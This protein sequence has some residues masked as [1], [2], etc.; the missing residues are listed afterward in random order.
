MTTRI[1]ESSIRRTARRILERKGVNLDE[2]LLEQQ[3]EGAVPDTISKRLFA[4]TDED[5][6][7]YGSTV[8]AWIEK[9]NGSTSP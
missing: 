3:S 6:K 4:L 2:W 8:E 5:V 1:S 9:L 7:V